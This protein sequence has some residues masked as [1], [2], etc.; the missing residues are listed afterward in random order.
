MTRA[1]VRGFLT[2]L[3]QWPLFTRM[4]AVE[5][6]AAGARVLERRTLVFREFVRSLS[7]AFQAA[8]E[9]DDRVGEPSEAV[10]MAVVGGIGELVLQQIVEQGV[11]ALPELEPTIVELIERVAYSELPEESS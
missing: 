10:L 3:A 1:G 6:R 11:A 5:A 2:T 7:A 8:R 9:V 4:H